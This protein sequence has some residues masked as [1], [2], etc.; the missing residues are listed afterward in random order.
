MDSHPLD[1]HRVAH[2]AFI[3]TD[4]LPLIRAAQQRIVG[5]GSFPPTGT[6]TRCHTSARGGAAQWRPWPTCIRS[7]DYKFSTRQVLNDAGVRAN[8][9]V[10]T[11]P[12]LKSTSEPAMA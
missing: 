1:L 4:M 10:S 5:Q 7:P 2:R 11:L 12:A 9:K 3:Q 6:C 8:S